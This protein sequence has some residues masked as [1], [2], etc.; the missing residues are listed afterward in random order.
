MVSCL[1]VGKDGGT[2]NRN[3]AVGKEARLLT[4]VVGEGHDY[5]QVAPT[6]EKVSNKELVSRQNS[7]PYTETAEPSVSTARLNQKAGMCKGHRRRKPL[8]GPHTFHC[9]RGS[10]IQSQNRQHLGQ[11]L[12]GSVWWKGLPGKT[13]PGR[14]STLKEGPAWQSSLRDKGARLP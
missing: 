3:G 13:A 9:G 6:C 1:G 11:M 10:D 12:R 14:T 7:D 4:E 8:N 5:G 2:A